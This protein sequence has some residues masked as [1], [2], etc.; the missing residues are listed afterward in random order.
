[1]G[2][3]S[4]AMI[5][6]GYTVTATQKKIYINR[7]IIKSKWTIGEVTKNTLPGDS[8]YTVSDVGYRRKFIMVA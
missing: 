6:Q 3:K 2:K 1:M 7:K 5:K 4:E 8:N